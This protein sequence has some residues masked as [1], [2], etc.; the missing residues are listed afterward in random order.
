MGLKSDADFLKWPRRPRLGFNPQH[1]MGPHPAG[2]RPREQGLRHGRTSRGIGDVVCGSN[3]ARFVALVGIFLCSVIVG[4]GFPERAG[5]QLKPA[6]SSGVRCGVGTGWTNVIDGFESAPMPEE[7]RQSAKLLVN[8]TQPVKAGDRSEQ[9]LV[10]NVDQSSTDVKFFAQRD[11]Q[12]LQIIGVAEPRQRIDEYRFGFDVPC[13]GRLRLVLHERGS[14]LVSIEETDGG[15]DY[16]GYVEVPWAITSS[17]ETLKTWFELE[18]E[19]IVQKV[20]AQKTEESYVFD[21]TFTSIACSHQ[22]AELNVSDAVNLSI[23]DYPAFCPPVAIFWA[24]N[25]WLPM[26]GFEANVANDHGKVLTQFP[27]GDACSVPGVETWFSFDFEVPCRMHD[28]CYALR[29]AGLS[30]TI[31]D[32]DCDAAFWYVMEAHCNNRSFL[33]SADCRLKRDEYFAAVQLPWV[34][35]NPNP[36]LVTIRNR[37]SFLCADVPGSS[38]SY[39]ATLVQWTCNWTPNQQFRIWPVPGLPGYFEL[40][41]SHSGLCARSGFTLIVQGVCDSSVANGQVWIWSYN[42]SDL[43]T[44]RTRDSGLSRCWDIPGSSVNLGSQIGHWPCAD[45]LNQL[46]QV[47]L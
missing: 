36:G 37:N 10:I 9:D 23:D 21:P 29:R 31:S 5:A 26:W 12:T 15:I 27:S 34:I 2:S 17:G 47:R 35:T 1:L 43:W 14:V 39:G 20:D 19:T 7:I 18:G 6:E 11:Y 38:M 40:R 4:F 22:R 32:G 25:G 28:Y 45:T 42:G 46:W 13:D 8:G 16:L 33:L 3:C 41:P 24:A 30:G 44:I